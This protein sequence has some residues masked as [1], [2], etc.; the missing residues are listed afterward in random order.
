MDALIELRAMWGDVDRPAFNGSDTDE[1][2]GRVQ[3]RVVLEGAIKGVRLYRNN[4]GALKDLTGRPVRYGLANDSKAR[5]T[6]LKSGDLIGIDSRPIT[7]AEVGQP[8]GRFVS[9]ECKHSRW[10][11]GED[12]AREGPQLEWAQLIISLGGD[13]AFCSGEGTL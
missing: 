7:L 4:V 6:V 1:S 9:R 5:N 13:A 12:P 10:T 3:S 8:R 11:F 2:E